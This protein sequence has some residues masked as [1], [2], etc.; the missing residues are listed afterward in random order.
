MPHLRGSSVHPGGQAA[1]P[2]AALGQAPYRAVATNPQRPNTDSIRTMTDRTAAIQTQYAHGSLLEAIDGALDQIGHAPEDPS[3]EVLAAVDEFH[4]RGQAA[5]RELLDGIALPADARVLDVGCGIGGTARLVA[6]ERGAE[7]LGVDLCAEYCEVARALTERV[8]LADQVSFRQGSALDLPVPTGSFD[9][10][11][12]E[13]VQM[14]VEGKETYFAEIARV[15][16]PG[17]ALALHEIV[18][19]P[20]KGSHHYPVPWADA[21]NVS[22]LVPPARLRAVLTGAG[23]EITDWQDRTEEGRAWFE[24]MLANVREEGPPP[25]GLHLLMGP[26]AKEKMKN[27]TRNLVEERIGIISAIARK[28]E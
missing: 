2:R 9:L 1:H 12:S 25:L 20:A 21:P 15:L 24:Q 13:H 3:P 18:A 5:T 19:G 16:R 27:V 23:L 14:N 6:E 8:G 11:L 4:I 22:F 28:P 10:V 26:S 7:V 17:A